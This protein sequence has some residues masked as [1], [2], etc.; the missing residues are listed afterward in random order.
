MRPTKYQKKYCQQVYDFL[1]EGASVTEFAVH[2]G[3]T[4]ST[5]YKWAEDHQEF[6]DALTRAQ[7]ASRSYWEKEL[8][9]N[10]MLNR[11]C[12]AP[13]VKLYFANRFNWHD[14]VEQDNKSSDSSMS[15][16]RRVEIVAVSPDDD[17][18]D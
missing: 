16:P 10:L 4:R 8:R 1:A 14:K 13:L 9:T 7:E 2:I 11:E 12:N 5:V 17:N 6:S 15:P 18:A 3:V